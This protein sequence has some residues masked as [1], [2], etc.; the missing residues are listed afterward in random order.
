MET[1]NQQIIDILKNC[2]D[3]DSLL[4]I[5]KDGIIEYGWVGINYYGDPVG[6]HILEIY[7]QLC[8]S[9]STVMRALNTGKPIF[10]ERQE[11]TNSLGERVLMESTD[12]PIISEGRVQCVVDSTKFFVVDQRIIR[13]STDTE[14]PVF[15]KIITQDNKMEELK[16]QIRDVASLDSPVL[17]YGETGTGKELVAEALHNSGKRRKQPFVSQNCAAIPS[18]LLESIFFGT[19]KGSYTGAI[20]RKGLFEEAEGGTLFLDELSA[21]DT[22]LQAKLLKVIEE[23]KV[24]RLGGNRDIAF[25]VRII[26]AVNEDPSLLIREQRLREDLFYRLAVVQL[27]IPPLRERKDD[28]VLLTRY[29]VE[30]YSRDMKRN[31][32]RVN[33]LVN[34]LFQHYS[35]PGNVREL[36][37]TIEGAI[38]I[39]KNEEIDLEDITGKVGI[40]MQGGRILESCTPK[41]F[42]ESGFSLPKELE[43]YEREI[44]KQALEQSNS[45]TSAANLLG[46]SSQNLNYKRQKYRL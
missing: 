2:E 38:A 34:E 25:D 29:F 28:I 19:E 6:K 32:S 14:D 44:I 16:R 42:L 43:K 46:I 21:M 39:A 11:L 12:I 3:T 5:N 37:N 13:E 18:N 33:P 22:G 45:F 17:I 8:D 9:D 35:W 7:P 41:I 36:K 10:K 20:S 4:L 24:R 15:D 26:A 40:T 23:K 27:C 1:Y 31:I 30:K